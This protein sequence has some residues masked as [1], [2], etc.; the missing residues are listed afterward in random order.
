MSVLAKNLKV[1]CLSPQN[2]HF[3]DSRWSG[4]DSIKK[5]FTWNLLSDFSKFIPQFKNLGFLSYSVGRWGNTG[6]TALLS[7]FIP[8]AT[9]R[10]EEISS[11][12]AGCSFE[13][14]T[15][16]K[17]HLPSTYT[18]NLAF[19]ALGCEVLGRM[20][21]LYLEIRQDRKRRQAITR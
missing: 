20:K 1:N 3:C 15:A 2:D 18:I 17:L 9:R 14:L 6:H 4:K 10:F 13:Y 21:H 8:F 5:E 12:L 11:P 7:P 16:L 19:D